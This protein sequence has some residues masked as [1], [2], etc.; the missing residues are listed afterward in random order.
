M[1]ASQFVVLQGPITDA[2]WMWMMEEWP[3]C[4]S[5]EPYDALMMMYSTLLSTDMKSAWLTASSD[6]ELKY[7]HLCCR[8]TREHGQRAPGLQHKTAM[9][10]RT[11]LGQRTSCPVRTPFSGG[12]ARCRWPACAGVRPSSAPEARDW[13]DHAVQS[14]EG[15]RVGESSSVRSSYQTNNRSTRMNHLSAT[16]TCLNALQILI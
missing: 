15:Q 10:T 14:D 16:N 8:Q 4:C 13:P 9:Q 1:H 7:F 12:E 11:D 2:E 6:T 3:A 5:P